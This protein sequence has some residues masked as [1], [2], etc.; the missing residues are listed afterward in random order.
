[1]SETEAVGPWTKTDE[2]RAA[3]KAIYAK[4]KIADVAKLYGI[5][6]PYE[7]YE[8]GPSCWPSNYKSGY[9]MNPGS[10]FWVCKGCGNQVASV[11]RGGLGDSIDLQEREKERAFTFHRDN[12][13][14]LDSQP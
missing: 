5:E 8:N 11:Q 3:D 2:E 14:K 4:R 9:T 10:R 1:M 7:V 12:C 6:F 13:K